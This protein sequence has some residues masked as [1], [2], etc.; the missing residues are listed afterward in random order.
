[1]KINEIFKSISGEAA[2]AGLP[3]IFVRTYGCNLRCTYCDTMYAVE[4]GEFTQMTP[5]EVLEECNKL[6][7][8]HVI[9]TGGEPLIQPDMPDLIWLLTRNGYSVEIETNGA[10]NL[11]QFHDKL[12][13]S[14][15]E[16]SKLTY[17]MD[18]KSFSS[19]M[20]YKMVRSNLEFLG[21][22]DVIKFVVGCMEDLE[23]MEI[24]LD[25]NK[26]IMAKV[27]VSPV[28]GQIEPE[29]I[30]QFLLDKKL[31]NVRVQL[32]MHKLIWDKNKRGV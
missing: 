27:F 13:L 1:M 24:L 6:G 30:V 12:T 15:L 4:G 20:A 18:Y 9:L 17:T 16:L 2:F 10:V 31:Y 8:K 21:N 19:G 29:Q 22:N 14:M 28:F 26:D 3:C 23:Q 7:P 32:Q 5:H 25:N 11:Q